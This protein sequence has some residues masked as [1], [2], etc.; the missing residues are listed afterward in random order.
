CL[1][2]PDLQPCPICN[3]TT[4]VCNGGDNDG[5]PCTP[6]VTPATP[7]VDFPTSHDCPP[8]AEAKVG[9]LPIPYALTTGTSSK[10]SVDQPS[11]P[12]VFCGFCRR[13]DS[14]TFKRPP[15]ACS[16][17]ADCAAIS[18]FTACAQRNRGAFDNAIATNITEVGTPGGDLTDHASHA[19]TLVSVFCIPPSYNAI[20]D[21]SADIAG[22][23]A[24]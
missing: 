19:A 8:P 4:G 12:N 13:P 7:G 11:Q 18:P 21:P 20:V 16:S 22:P 15:V 1:L 6:G 9:A 17:D 5:D 24:V 10:N 23:G 2:D 3:T 14:P